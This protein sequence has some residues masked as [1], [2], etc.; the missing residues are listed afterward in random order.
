MGMQILRS[1]KSRFESSRRDIPLK[2]NG[3]GESSFQQALSNFYILVRA[4]VKIFSKPH[5]QYG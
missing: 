3:K 1:Y 2:N 4:K 5:F